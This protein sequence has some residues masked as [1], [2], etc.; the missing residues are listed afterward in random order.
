MTISFTKMH[1][2]GND[3]VVIDATQ[4]SYELT[5]DLVQQMASRHLGIG[6]DQLLLIEKPK[7]LDADF[8]YRIFNADG[9]E[10][11]QCGNGARCIG[12]YIHERG[13]SDQPDIKLQ[14][15]GGIVHV[16]PLAD[17]QV[18][19]TL[20]APQFA[21][22]QIPF[23]TTENSELYELTLEANKIKFAVVNVGNPHAVVTV[24]A[25]D[26]QQAAEIGSKLCEHASFPQQVN[27][28]FMRVITSDHI[29]LA[30]YERGAGM[31]QACGSGACAAM[32]VGR[33]AGLLGE[34]VQ[35]TQAGGDLRII[36]P[37]ESSQLIMQGFASFVFNG[38]WL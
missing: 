28:G 7:T 18:A 17:G 3:F 4:N 38:E 19:V 32:A 6:F 37:G 27:V 5:S 21:P 8:N 9:G 35:V 23:N 2:L 31:T 20:D 14:T 29:E 12:R 26:L 24:P 25:I 11:E 15:L 30:V 34:S 33:K 16:K 22:E 1:G 36:W 10:V 13:L